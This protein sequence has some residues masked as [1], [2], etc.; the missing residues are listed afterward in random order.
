MLRTPA[1]SL[2][3]TQMRGM[4]LSNR[5]AV[6]CS[7]SVFAV[8][9]WVCGVGVSDA[10][11]AC[12]AKRWDLIGERRHEIHNPETSQFTGTLEGDGG[13]MCCVLVEGPNRLFI[14]KFS[15]EFKQASL[16]KYITEKLIVAID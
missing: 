2:V 8:L 5:L 9:E 7:I 16:N 1:L 4:Q 3:C 10:G 14:I 15:C 11:G 6:W 12:R 13:A